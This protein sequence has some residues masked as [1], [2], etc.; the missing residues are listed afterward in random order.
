MMPYPGVYWI[1][2]IL[3]L[4]HLELWVGVC[5]RFWRILGCESPIQSSQSLL[6][7][8]CFQYQ[9][10]SFR[11]RPSMLQNMSLLLQQ[12]TITFKSFISLSLWLSLFLSDCMMSWCGIFEI[13]ITS[14]VEAIYPC[15]Y[16]SYRS[17]VYIIY[18][19]YPIYL[20]FDRSTYLCP[21]IFPIY[22]LIIDQSTYP[23]IYPNI[24]LS[25]Y[26]IHWYIHLSH[27][28]SSH[29]ISSYL[30]LSYLILSYLSIYLSIY[31]SLAYLTFSYL[32]IY[33]S[34]E[35]TTK[36]LLCRMG[37]KP[38]R[39]KTQGSNVC[40]LMME[41]RWFMSSSSSSSSKISKKTFGCCI[42]HSFKR[43]M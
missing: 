33:P 24:Y 8:Q 26:G 13:N 16:L 21:S 34:P 7:V 4:N 1:K 38:S 28:I 18:I 39:A 23:S 6:N 42:S 43:I 32:Y 37:I 9:T 36:N 22:L 2:M 27:L 10:T 14:E 29:L 31:P 20:T 40:N 19:F 11:D 35:V 3:C 5:W 25:I 12:A 41:F 17:N 30:I 15:R